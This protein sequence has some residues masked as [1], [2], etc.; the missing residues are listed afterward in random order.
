MRQK[1]K[2]ELHELRFTNERNEATIDDLR[3]LVRELDEERMKLAA[4]NIEHISGD[5]RLGPWCEDCIHVGKSVTTPIYCM[6]AAELNG[7]VPKPVVYCKKRVHEHCS[8]W[9]PLLKRF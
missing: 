7:D 9:E 6:T 3:R 8:G 4:F 5:C 2:R 1:L